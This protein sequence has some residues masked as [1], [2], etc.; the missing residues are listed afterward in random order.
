MKWPKQLRHLL[1]LGWLVQ[2]RAN[3]TLLVGLILCPVWYSIGCHWYTRRHDNNHLPQPWLTQMLRLGR[4][5]VLHSGSTGYWQMFKVI[6]IHQIEQ[7]RWLAIISSP[8]NPLLGLL[9]SLGTGGSPEIRDYSTNDGMKM[10]LGS[11]PST[12]G[13]EVM[14]YAGPAPPKG[15]EVLYDT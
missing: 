4:I 9:L 15:W 3:F 2:W 6:E 10:L 5:H 12:V 1:A 8:P 13:D 11:G 7:E 14:S